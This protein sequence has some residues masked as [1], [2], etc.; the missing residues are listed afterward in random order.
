MHLPLPPA[1]CPPDPPALIADRGATLLPAGGCAAVIVET[2]PT[3]ATFAWGG[4][5]LPEDQA[6][7]YTLAL[8]WRRLGERGGA[9]LEVAFPGG[10]FM[11]RDGAYG[12]WENDATWAHT[13]WQPLPV[14]SSEGHHLRLEQVGASL[15]VWL[16]GAPLLP[17]QLAATP[18][19][20]RLSIGLKGGPGDRARMWLDHVTLH[21]RP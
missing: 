8:W 6:P 19:P 21:P 17:H 16:D 15:R 10:T 9:P 20:G 2:A 18:E 11:L 7:A 12:W 14:L 3:S 1:T 13:G 5:R 4:A